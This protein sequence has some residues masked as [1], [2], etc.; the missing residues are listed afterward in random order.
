[1]QP[2]PS[3]RG[4]AGFGEAEGERGPS[5]GGS[6]LPQPQAGRGEAAQPAGGE[7]F[8]LRG[9]IATSVMIKAFSA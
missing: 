6:V 2:P 8:G 9:G 5:R 7:G 1:M 4:F 3:S